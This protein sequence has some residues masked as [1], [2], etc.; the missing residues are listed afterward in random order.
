MP[1]EELLAKSEHS[2]GDS[3]TSHTCICILHMF[4]YMSRWA[5]YHIC[6]SQFI[7]T[8]T[9]MHDIDYEKSAQARRCGK[10]AA[11][12]FTYKVSTENY[13][14]VSMSAFHFTYKISTENY[15]MVLMSAFHFTCKISTENSVMVSRSAFPALTVALYSLDSVYWFVD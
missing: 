9:S 6:S 14:M 7:H 2:T 15:V 10:W 13:V 11:F 4:I 12:H 1:H 5:L 3:V 8:H